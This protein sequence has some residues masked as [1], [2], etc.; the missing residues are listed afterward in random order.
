MSLT[1]RSRMIHRKRHRHRGRGAGRYLDAALVVHCESRGC[2]GVY[3]FQNHRPGFRTFR[4]KCPSGAGRILGHAVN[5]SR[6]SSRIVVLAIDTGAAAGRVIFSID[7]GTAAVIV[8]DSANAGR[9]ILARCRQVVPDDRAR[10]GHNIRRH[11]S[12]VRSQS[13]TEDAVTADIEISARLKCSPI[14]DVVRRARAGNHS[15]KVRAV[16]VDTRSLDSISVTALLY[17]PLNCEPISVPLICEK[18]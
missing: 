11:D 15:S 1:A 13:P 16:P 14:L 4:L 12:G 2:V 10:A 5:S 9:S 3:G 17:G 18:L 8:I 7:A 6:H